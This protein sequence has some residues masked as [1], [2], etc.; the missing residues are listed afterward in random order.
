MKDAGRH[1]IEEAF[2]RGVLVKLMRLTSEK[3]LGKFTSKS[4]FG[5]IM[6]PYATIPNL[7]RLLN[8]QRRLL[9]IAQIRIE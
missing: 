5:A 8:T 7:V 9:G 6:A 1:E 3:E 2:Q 4:D